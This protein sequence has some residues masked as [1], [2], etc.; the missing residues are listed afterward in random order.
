MCKVA[1]LPLSDASKNLTHKH[2]AVPPI[3]REQEEYVVIVV[4]CQEHHGK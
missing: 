3:K 2:S 1:I 4:G